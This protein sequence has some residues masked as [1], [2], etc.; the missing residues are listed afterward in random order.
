MVEAFNKAYQ[1]R[2]HKPLPISHELNSWELTARSMELSKGYGLLPDL[3]VRNNRFPHLV[4]VLAPTLPYTLQAIY[5]KGC[6][7]SS[8]AKAFLDMVQEGIKSS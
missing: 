3:V 5:L 2:Y 4:P 6:S 7:L 8:T 1:R